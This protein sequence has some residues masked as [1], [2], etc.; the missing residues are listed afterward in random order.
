MVSLEKFNSGITIQAEKYKYFLPNAINTEWKWNNPKINRLLEEASFELGQLNSFAKLVPNIDLFIHLHITK[1]AVISSRIEGTQTHFDEAFL[2]KENIH[3]ERKDDWQEVQN[4]TN[5]MNTAIAELNNFP[6]SSR[7]ILLIH[8]LL[9]E[10]VRGENKTPGDYRRSQNWIGGRTLDD[11][12][13][14]PPHHQHLNQLMGDFENFLH[15]ESLDLPKLIKAAIMH[16]QFETIHPFLDGNGQIGRLL[17]TLFLIEKNV[18]SMP[19]LYLSGFFEKDKSLYYDNLTRVRTHNDITQW[20]KYF[21][22]GISETSKQAVNT[23]AGVIELKEKTEKFIQTSFGK[24][25]NTG[26]KLHNHLLQKPLITVKEVQEICNLTPKSAGDLINLYVNNGK[27]KEYT[28]NYRNR[29][30][31]YDEYLN[32]FGD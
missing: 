14:V 29:I 27:L 9:L 16:Y 32:L 31:A 20:I 17:I 8:K 28:G 18:L 2:Q 24:R 30:F 26:L 25:V 3:P 21:L 13:F 15:N 22:K 23:L 4:Y 12:V 1:E 5:A 6:I 11:A 19:L 10:G 7:I